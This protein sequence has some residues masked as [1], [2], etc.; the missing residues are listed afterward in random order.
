MKNTTEQV[1][2]NGCGE[3]TGYDY[4]EEDTKKEFEQYAGRKGYNL[5]YNQEYPFFYA[6]RKTEEVWSMYHHG[7][8][9]GRTF[10]VKSDE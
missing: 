4:F 8:V 1:K 10:K 3:D 2:P 5:E 7:H 9:A 6:E